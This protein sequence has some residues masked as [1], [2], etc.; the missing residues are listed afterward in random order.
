VDLS[1]FTPDGVSTIA[2][3]SVVL[4]SFFTAALTASFG[5]G[6]GLALLAIMSALFPPAAVIP[7]H[8]V[9]QLGSNLSRFGLQRAHVVWP[10]LLW[11]GLGGLLGTAA[12][13]RL[14]VEMPEE[15]LQ[16]GVGAFVL[17]TV[18][19]PMPKG[20]APG[21]VSFFTTGA[22]GAFLTM[23][24]GATGP[25]AATMLS[26]TKLDRLKIVATHAGCMVL[27]HSLKT[28]AFGAIGFAFGRW[29]LLILAV[30]IAGFLGTWLG[31]R[32]LRD[33]PEKEF[34][35]G[36]KLMLTLI[37]VYLVAAAYASFKTD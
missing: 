22:A 18:W 15:L 37:G 36:F 33:M 21:K 26:T 11:F 13:A 24:F 28:L 31:T 35:R 4:A 16:A 19:G 5:L 12:G 10:I 27:Q 25:I 20:F 6:G 9:A 2:A 29:A 34:K 17:Y 3:A 7:V 8:G 30:L 32:L 14:Y 23:F 1:S